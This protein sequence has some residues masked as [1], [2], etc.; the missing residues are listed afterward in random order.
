MRRAITLSDNPGAPYIV[1]ECD[2]KGW[3]G[4]HVPHLTATELADHFAALQANDPNGDW[5]LYHVLTDAEEGI[6]AHD[7]LSDEDDMWAYDETG[8]AWVDGLVWS[9]AT[10]DNGEEVAP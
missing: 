8:R 7:N 5:D 1:A 9:T 6:I 4:F 10:D 2:D 3:N